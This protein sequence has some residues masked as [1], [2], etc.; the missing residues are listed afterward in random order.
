MVDKPEIGKEY[1][2]LTIPVPSTDKEKISAIMKS[3]VCPYYDYVGKCI[4]VVYD[5]YTFPHNQYLFL[6]N[7]CIYRY[8]DFHYMDFRESE[9]APYL[10][11]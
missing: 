3:D 7:G 6:C 11:K 4:D 5:P 2:L 8:N 10:L 1:Y 9:D